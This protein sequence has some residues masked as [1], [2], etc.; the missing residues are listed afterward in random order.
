MKNDR[1]LVYVASYYQDWP[2]ARRAMKTLREAGVDITYDWTVY[3]DTTAP[4]GNQGTS[5][6]RKQAAQLDMDGVRAADVV[7]VLT[8]DQKEQGAGYLVEMGMAIALDKIVYCTG[9]LMNRSVFHELT[10]RFDTDEAAI[11]DII[12]LSKEF[13]RLS[14]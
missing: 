13:T 10:T 12:H 2:R 8:P 14:K 1:L 5:E 9:L 6:E 11:A 4:D 3:A 7:L